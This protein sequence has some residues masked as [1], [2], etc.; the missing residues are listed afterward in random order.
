MSNRSNAMVP[1][2]P[3]DRVVTVLYVV[4]VAVMVATVIYAWF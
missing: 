4:A 2:R 3:R 1:R